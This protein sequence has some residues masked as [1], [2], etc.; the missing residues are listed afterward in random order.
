MLKK[1]LTLKNKLGLHAR[2]SM[3]LIDLS[4]RYACKIELFNGKRRMNAKDI[5]QVMS[6]GAAQNTSI[7]IIT[8]GEDEIEALSEIEKLFEDGFGERI[9]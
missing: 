6:L 8:D 4:S 9:D 1:T 5:L 2:A 3:K 7:D